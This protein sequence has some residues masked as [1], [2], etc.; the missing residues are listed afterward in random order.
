MAILQLHI[1]NE[2]EFCG[3][4]GYLDFES[5][6]S[7]IVKCSLFYQ[8]ELEDNSTDEEAMIKRCDECLYSEVD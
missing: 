2:D 5:A 6:E 3:S 8:Q 1:E 7:S 4:C